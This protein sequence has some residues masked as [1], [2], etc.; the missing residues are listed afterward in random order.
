MCEVTSIEEC[1]INVAGHDDE[2]PDVARLIVLF[3]DLFLQSHNTELVRG[4]DEPIY[5]PADQYHS[6]HRIVFAHGF[7]NSALHEI[8]HWCIA[9]KERRLLEDFGYWYEPDGRDLAQ[10]IAFETV[11]VKP[12]AL[13][14]IFAKCCGRRFRVSTDNLSLQAEGAGHQDEK[15]KRAVFAEVQRRLS[16]GLPGRA[17]LFAE[18]LIAQFNPDFQLTMDAFSL[19]ELV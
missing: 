6:H 16:M 7:F 1:Q 4:D 14:W 3:N 13:E 19:R 17:K 9:G 12:Q 5:L 10:Q 18:S 15:F 11:E 8:S 2:S